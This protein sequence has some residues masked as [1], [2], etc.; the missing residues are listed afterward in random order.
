MLDLLNR[1]GFRA[2]RSGAVAFDAFYHSLLSEDRTV[3]GILS[4]SAVGLSSYLR[5]LF[6]AEGSSE[7][8]L[9]YKKN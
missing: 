4:A 6:G 8:Y 9:A 1:S 3:L 7:L 5:G 2:E